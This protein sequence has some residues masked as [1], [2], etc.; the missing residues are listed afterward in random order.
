MPI[1]WHICAC[2]HTGRK[3]WAGGAAEKAN[4]RDRDSKRERERE[5]DQEKEKRSEIPRKKRERER[6]VAKEREEETEKTRLG[7]EGGGAQRGG[8]W[9][10]GELTQN[11]VSA[12]PC[13]SV[14]QG[15]ILMGVGKGL[16]WWGGGGVQ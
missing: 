7:R 2:H 9:G 15:N 12:G 8:G 1:L 3:R 4:E 13:G 14:L 10:L 5:T 6:D 16:G 11:I